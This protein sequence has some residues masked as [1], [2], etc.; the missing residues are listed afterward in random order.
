MEVCFVDIGQ[1][2]CNVV[3]L[4]NRRAIVI[5]AGGRQSDTVI[6]LL[7]S[8][9]ID[10][11]ERLILTHSHED[12]SFGGPQLLTAFQRRIGMVHFPHDTS[13]LASVFFKRITEQVALGYL[14]EDQLRR[15]EVDP[16]PT[17][18]YKQ[19]GLSLLL[20]APSFVQNLRSIAVRDPNATSGILLLQVG[21]SRIVFGGDSTLMQWKGV[22]N[23]IGTLNCDIITVPHHGGAIWS[24]R[25]NTE[26]KVNYEA[27]IV[28]ELD[29][30]YSSAVKSNLAIISVGSHNTFKHPRLEVLAALRRAG[31]KVLCTQM[32][33]QCCADLEDQRK[34]SLPL[35]HECRSVTFTDVR[36]GK[37]RNVACA[38]TVFA[39]LSGSTLTMNRLGEH[40]AMVDRLTI[41]GTP[42]CR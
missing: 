34:S 26:S 40:Q 10:Y 23:R 8:L 13:L 14:R 38:S 42:K 39:D 30:L 5:D 3:L 28:T 20:L 33:S 4:G 29:W 1:G 6:R 18:L 35:I 32:T 21:S 11:L 9:R 37:S 16:Q 17:I 12:H 25:T 27:R 24:A 19:P 15:L 36:K 31:T 2:S 41:S 7:D 22:H